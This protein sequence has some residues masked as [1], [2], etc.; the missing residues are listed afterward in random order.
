MIALNKKGDHGIIKKNYRKIQ[1]N[2][3]KEIKFILKYVVF[4]V[5]IRNGDITYQW[6]IMILTFVISKS[7]NFRK[8]KN[9]LKLELQ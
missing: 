4:S 7:L 5:V 2:S 1:N 6:N 9:D 3:K 8:L